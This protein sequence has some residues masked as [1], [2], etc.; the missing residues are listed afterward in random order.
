MIISLG[1]EPIDSIFSIKRKGLGKLNTPFPNKDSTS[2]VPLLDMM[3]LS[4]HTVFGV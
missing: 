1:P 4:N 2:D 3:F